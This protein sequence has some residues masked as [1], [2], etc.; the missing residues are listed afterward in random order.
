MIDFVT[1]IDTDSIF[2][3]IGKYLDTVNPKWVE[4]SENLKLKL[5]LNIANKIQDYVNERTFNETQLEQ[6]NS[7]VKDFKIGLKHELVAKTALFIKKKRYAYWAINEEGI[8]TDKV[9]VKGIEIIRSDT[10]VIIRKYLD[11]ILNMIMRKST[12]DEIVDKIEKCKKEMLICELEDISANI[13]L[14]PKGNNSERKSLKSYFKSDTELRTDLKNTAGKTL[15]IPWHIKGVANYRLLLETF[16]LK[17]QYEWLEGDEKAKVIYLKDNQF[18]M[19][20][21]CYV[22]WPKEFEE[23]GIIPDRNIMIEKYFTR[24]IEMLLE[25]LNK[26][27]ILDLHKQLA[28]N[29]FF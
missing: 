15:G 2:L 12:E 17:N 5:I 29:T 10:P 3:A 13:T 16:N 25:P 7:N 6:Y 23:N 21:I 24:K 27:Y 18:G 28:F 8:D 11:N 19:N 4:L 26:T 1:Y 9:K 14:P 20:S 22:E